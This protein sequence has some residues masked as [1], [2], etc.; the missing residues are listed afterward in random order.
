MTTLYCVLILC[1]TAL[2][3]V[4][5]R[6][7][8]V[9]RFTYAR[10][11]HASARWQHSFAPRPSKPCRHPWRGLRHVQWPP[12]WAPF[13]PPPFA[14]PHCQYEAAMRAVLS[15]CSSGPPMG[16]WAR[17]CG[18]LAASVLLDAQSACRPLTLPPRLP[19]RRRQTHR[20]ERLRSRRLR[21]QRRRP[22]PPSFSQ[23]V[24]AEGAAVRRG[25][26]RSPPQS[27]S[28]SQRAAAAAASRVP[29]RTK[30]G[31]SASRLMA[32]GF[33]CETTG[34]KADR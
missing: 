34:S 31:A 14:V 2:A 10:A 9:P 23:R 20:R 12:C 3:G 4:G 13:C 24:A 1:L 6:L 8:R 7:S 29:Q 5:C 28:S 19:H 21:Q 15:E 32:H 22:R 16:S 33:H 11:P 18:V 30:C 26:P 17:P 25:P 27:P